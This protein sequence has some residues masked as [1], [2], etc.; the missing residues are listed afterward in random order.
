MG[1]VLDSSSAVGGNRQR[2][3]NISTRSIP[4]MARSWPLSLKAVLR[5]S[6]LPFVLR[7]LRLRN[8]AP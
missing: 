8:G 7:G 2:L 3:E 5:I 4:Q 6:M 1:G